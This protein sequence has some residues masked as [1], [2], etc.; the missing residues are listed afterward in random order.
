M[1]DLFTND[2]ALDTEELKRIVDPDLVPES[3]RFEFRWFGKAE[4]K[5]NAFTPTLASLDYDHERSVKPDLAEG[6]AIIEGENLEVLKC[7][8]SS[9]R[10]RIKCIYIDPPYN[11]DKD[12]V[13][14]DTWKEDR[15]TYWEHIGVTSDG[16]KI[17]T[18]TKAEGRFHSNWLNMIYPRL[19]LARQLLSSDG[20]IYISIDDNEVHHLRRI[21]DEVFGEECRMAQFTWRTDGNFDNQAKIKGCHEYILMYAKNADNFPHPPVI[22]PGVPGESKLFLPEIR[23]TIVKNGP[24]NPASE[25]ALPDGFPCDFDSGEIPARVHKWP[26]FKKAVRVKN[27]KIEGGAVAYSG[28]SSRHLIDAFI[29][30]GFTP[31]DDAKG[32]KT[33]FELTST[34]AIEA[35]KDRSEN[36]SHVISVLQDFGNTQSESAGLEESGMPFD[37]YPKPVKLLRYLV[38][39]VSADDF[40]TLDFFAGSGTTGEAVMSLNAERGGKRRFILVQFP[41]QIPQDKAAYRV[42]FKKISEITI[43]RNKK[44]VAQL[45]EAADELENQTRKALPGLENTGPPVIRPGFK[46]Y[47]IAKSRFPRTEFLPDPQKTD[48][49]N[50]EAL[51]SYIR[52]KESG[53]RMTFDKREI[54][55]EVLLKSGFMFDVKTEALANFTENMVFRA[56]DSQ[57]EATVCLDYHMKE[58]TI[59]NLKGM[60]GI[61]ICLEQALNTTKKW[62]LRVEFGERLVSF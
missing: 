19:L 36:Q 46:V 32:Q 6:N 9:Y 10:N 7:L 37:G 18:N 48:E 11:K 43:A 59:T 50:L 3:E 17:D 22:D 5:R 12:F 55:G 29:S 24:K 54:L 39:M 27:G 35:V 23:N 56:W 52:E 62:N 44:V 2:G 42:G 38:S 30:G 25:I 34:G 16:V 41:E 58:S 51:D 61:F 8:L 1:P 40:I 28:W 14:S 53:F 49:E 26:H 60:E 45:N 15:E 13:Y 33:R 21:C 47:R 20:V 57:K 31:V 4:A